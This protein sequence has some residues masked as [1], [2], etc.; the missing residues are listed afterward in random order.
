MKYT[1]FLILFFY[2]FITY[3]QVSESQQ[4]AIDSV[5]QIATNTKN[6]TEDRLKAYNYCC[7]KT[8]YSDYNQSLRNSREYL[9]LA[10]TT[11]NYKAICKAFH[12]LGLSEMMLGEFEKSNKTLEAGLQFSILHR[13]H[14]ATA[15]LYGDLGNLNNN[16]GNFDLAITYHQKCLSYA[17]ENNIFVEYARA[18]IN[19]G[20]IYKSKGKY[21]RSFETFQEAL[22][23]SENCN[24][25][26]FKSSIYESLGD[27][28]L[29]IKEY[30]TAEK[31]YLKAI[32][33]ARRLSNSNRL[34]NS[35]NKLGQLHIKLK[36]LEKAQIYFDEA[37]HVATTMKASILEA[38]VRANLANLNLQ[39]NKIY[40]ALD[41][42]NLALSQYKKL[43]IKEDLDQA[44]IIA[45]K[46]HAILK[47]KKESEIYYT[48]AYDIAKKSNNITALKNASEGLAITY[49]ESEN[50]LKA[51]RFLKE[52][53]TYS[54]L[55]RNDEGIKE[56]IRFEMQDVY[57]QKTFIDSIKKINEIKELQFEYDK[58]EEQNKLRS[59]LAFFGIGLLLIILIFVAYFYNQ[60][61][62]VASVLAKKNKII[63][64]ALNDKELLLKEVHHRVKNNMQIVSS[65]L[66][67]KSHSTTDTIAKEAL[68]DSKK[69][70]DSMQ[71]AHLKMYQKG[72]YRHIDVIEY[73][74]DI[75]SLLLKPIK[76]PNDQFI[77]KGEELW[78]DVEQTQA[79]GFILHE[80]I[81]NSIKYAWRIGETKKVIIS[82]KKS[83]NTIKFNYKD[84]GR[85]L[86]NDSDFST[87]KTF[88]LKLIKSLSTRQL[89]GKIELE[90]TNGFS[91]NI[92]FN[93]I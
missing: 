77:V 57:K 79:L 93:A 74:N 51:N 70:I 34:I 67:L 91:V 18:K 13:V 25:I 64:D 46:T 59:Y 82:I 31:K 73:F 92:I 9:A 3:C 86:P 8:A 19:I 12:F 66:H 29:T 28:N 47:H 20:E 16:M 5:Y 44:Y 32:D 22:E 88:G 26:G 24:F 17:Q 58:K 71:L 40:D 54:N 68:L 14:R 48:K 80:L 52:Y 27:L 30:K 39:Q 83:E 10:Q 60:K 89:L 37:L 6:S 33:F 49:E 69:R 36:S 1:F 35:L 76:K 72:N 65:L 41:H 23:Y 61:K 42:I 90:N 2:S 50:L 45:A 87:T 75:I 78:L 55:V 38:K 43:K 21:K 62:K 4:H 56:I 15:E 11:Q 81:A 53:N 84:N 7:W 63:K 85:G